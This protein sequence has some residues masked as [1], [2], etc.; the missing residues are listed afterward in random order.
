MAEMTTQIGIVTMIAS[1]DVGHP[2]LQLLTVD[3][4]TIVGQ[5]TFPM[6]MP[7]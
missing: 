5:T 3:G 1:T 7:T 6:I 2:P 4:G